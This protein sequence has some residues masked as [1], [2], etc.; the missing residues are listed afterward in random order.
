[1]IVEI[2]FGLTDKRM[3]MEFWTLCNLMMNLKKKKKFSYVRN[4]RDILKALGPNTEAGL[5]TV[6]A[7]GSLFTSQYKGSELYI[8]I[9][10]TPLD[11]RIHS[12]IKKSEFL[13]FVPE[14]RNAGKKFVV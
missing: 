14:I 3:E 13:P 9:R 6:L 10:E 5:A 11:N 8:D 1:M 12:L 4:R 2:L 7:F